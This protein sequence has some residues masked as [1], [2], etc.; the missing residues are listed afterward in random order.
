MDID[1]ISR[2]IYRLSVED[3]WETD[4]GGIYEL[5]AEDDD[6]PEEEESEGEGINETYNEGPSNSDRDVYGSLYSHIINNVLTDEQRVALKRGECFF[7]HKKGHF[8]KSCPA[9][10]RKDKHGTE[11]DTEVQ[12]QTKARE[13]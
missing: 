11:V 13:L 1:R 2:G 6:N 9:R 7:C 10:H 5:G 3:D 8:A 4:D 12:A